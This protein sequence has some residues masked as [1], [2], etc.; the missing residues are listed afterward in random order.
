[1][2][3]YLSNRQQNLKIGIVSYTESN[4][5]LE[6]TGKV[7]IGTTNAQDYELY[8]VGDANIS[9]IVSATAF[10]G[11]GINLTDLIQTININKIEGIEIKDEGVGIGTTFT[12]INF[13]GS[14]VTATAVGSAATITISSGDIS[15]VG[16]LNISGIS[17]LGFFTNN[18][19][20]NRSITLGNNLLYYSAHKNVTIGTGNTFTVGSGSTVTFD[21]FNNLDDVKVDSLSI[22]GITTIGL[23]STST[24]PNNSQMS[25][26]LISNTQLRIKV[27]GS[28]GV[29]RS[30]DIILS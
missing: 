25:F 30:A 14:N 26:E 10:Y 20:I 15:D 21:R 5:V 11:S 8:V 22:S 6:V 27:R 28:D 2:S 13:V 1:M 16:S 9:G 4:T 12:S 17:T 7:G 23:G 19:A 3:K 29:L 18:Q 24:P